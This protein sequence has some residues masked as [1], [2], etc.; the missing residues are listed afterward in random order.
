M[1]SLHE[2]E[3]SRQVKVN[4]HKLSK[5]LA[6]SILGRI[7]L[8]SPRGFRDKELRPSL[9]GFLYGLIVIFPKFPTTLAL[10]MFV[11]RARGIVVESAAGVTHAMPPIICTVLCSEMVVTLKSALSNTC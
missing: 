3:S 5:D 8:I 4:I 7:V 10:G 9:V 11:Q 2:G 1:N 6:S